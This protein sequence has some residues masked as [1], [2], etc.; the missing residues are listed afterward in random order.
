MNVTQNT[1]M[2]VYVQVILYEIQIDIFESKA[3]LEQRD[4]LEVKINNRLHWNL[5]TV[6]K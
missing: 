4:D 3:V 5:G 1:Q 2:L 6:F